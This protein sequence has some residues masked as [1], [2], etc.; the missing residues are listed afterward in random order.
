M[1]GI[2]G[3]IGG[4]DLDLAGWWKRYFGRGGASGCFSNCKVLAAENF[5]SA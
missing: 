5:A 4:E 2:S 3:G 1:A